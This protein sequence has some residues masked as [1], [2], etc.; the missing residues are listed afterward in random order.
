[1]KTS[2][3]MNGT[4]CPRWD[5]LCVRILPADRARKRPIGSYGPIGLGAQMRTGRVPE[6]GSM[7]QSS[8]ICGG[9][10][11][12]SG[13][14]DAALPRSV[15]CENAADPNA[16]RRKCFFKICRK[17]ASDNQTPSGTAC[18]TSR[19]CPAHRTEPPRRGDQIRKSRNGGG[20]LPRP[21]YH[22]TE[23]TTG[24]V[25]H[26]ACARWNTLRVWGK[27]IEYENGVI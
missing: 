23:K 3:A 11:Q 2:G 19:V 27:E 9:Y 10:L 13:P 15:C 5:T 4:P 8:L 20:I 26:T 17:F 1:M 24:A 25:R 22:R 21:E 18:T 6:V 7:K 12:K 14:L 16:G